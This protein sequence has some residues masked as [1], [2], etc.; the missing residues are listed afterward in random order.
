MVLLIEK[1]IE[2]LRRLRNPEC[3]DTGM[4]NTHMFTLALRSDG[5][6]RPHLEALIH[7]TRRGVAVRSKSE[8]VVADIL[9]SLGISYSYE[10]PLVSRSNKNDFR[11]PDFTASFEGDVHYWEHLGMMNVPSYRGAWERK[12]Q[13][14]EDNRYADRLIVSED[15]ADGS[16]DAAKIEWIARS[17]ILQ[18]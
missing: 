6:E 4:R 8:V 14:Y 7:R 13:W 10:R 17:R 5:L 15:G 12:R 11:L 1:D 3:S 16:I 9:D 18:E 2:A